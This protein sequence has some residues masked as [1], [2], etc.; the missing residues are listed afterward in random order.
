[1]ASTPTLAA[2]I[3]MS[4]S[5]RAPY[6][7]SRVGQHG[8]TLLEILAVVIIIAIIVTFASLS[9][10]GRAQDDR[11]ANEA[12]RMDQLLKLAAD[13]ATVQG[14]QVGMLVASDGY[15]FYHFDAHHWTA[16]NDGPLR[17]RHLPEGMRLYFSQDKNNAVQIAAADPPDKDD[18]NKDKT[19]PQILFLS[20]GELTP[21][22]IELHAD[23]LAAYYRAEGKITGSIDVK[24]QI[25]GRT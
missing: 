10:S 9:L 16:Y 15:A 13:Q 11:L 3:W 18:K 24:R 1:M 6:L 21:F 5:G 4:D 2:G 12:E 8:F 7:R 14:E 20:S 23:N 17:E 19:A 22:T 25:P